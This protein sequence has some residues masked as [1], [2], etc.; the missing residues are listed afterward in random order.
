M[1][2]NEYKKYLKYVGKI[3]TTAAFIIPTHI[4]DNTNSPTK[5]KSII[6]LYVIQHKAIPD[7]PDR[8]KNITEKKKY[9]K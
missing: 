6:I 7:T 5:R 3:S 9:I 8:V 1:V 4:P 2:L